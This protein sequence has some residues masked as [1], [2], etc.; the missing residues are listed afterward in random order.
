M[1]ILGDQPERDNY[2]INDDA[3]DFFLTDAAELAKKHN[4]SVEVVVNAKY[5]LE[6]ERQNNIAVQDGDYTDEQ[7][8][9]IGEILT[10]IAIAYR[11]QNPLLH[12]LLT[13]P[14]KSVINNQ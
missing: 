14:D 6:I 13:N 9:G 5:A 4:I 11:G 3:L 8:G 7:A 10:R 2:R 12:P 1:G